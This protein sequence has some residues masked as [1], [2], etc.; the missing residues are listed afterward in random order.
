[1]TR[2]VFRNGKWSDA[3]L[4]EMDELRPGNVIKGL[5]VVEAP[6]TTL[7]I[8]EGWQARIDEYKIYWLSQGGE[9]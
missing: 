5:A 1:G 2:P 3:T 4:Y 9:R 7:F 8:P 6:N